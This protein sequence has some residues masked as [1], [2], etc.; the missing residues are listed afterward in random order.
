ML[1]MNKK[2]NGT[3]RYVKANQISGKGKLIQLIIFCILS[4]II[5]FYT[6]KR[7][8]SGKHEIS[9]SSSSLEKPKHI[10]L[11]SKKIKTTIS[12]DEY[13]RIHNFKMYLDSIANAPSGRRTFDSIIT[14]RPG[15]IESILIIENIYLSQKKEK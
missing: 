14:L 10:L 13:L 5:S 2:K 11:H 12:E 9:L 15:L 3:N 1:L 4:G 8:F 7:S 6:A